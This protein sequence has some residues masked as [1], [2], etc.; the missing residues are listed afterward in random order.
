[1]SKTIVC[2]FIRLGV[3]DKVRS[4]FVSALLLVDFLF[5]LITELSATIPNSSA[6][7]MTA[8]NIGL[9]HLLNHTS[10]TGIPS[11]L[12]SCRQLRSSALPSAV[13]AASPSSPQQP[14]GHAGTFACDCAAAY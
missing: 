9:L 13:H 14:H 1:M 8:H 5:S 2:F 7:R 10:K 4:V 12:N 3:Q 6:Q 11:R